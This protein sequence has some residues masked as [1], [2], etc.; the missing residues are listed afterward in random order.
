MATDL[1]F[2]DMFNIFSIFVLDK[3]KD[4][5]AHTYSKNL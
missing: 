3:D 5:D 1:Q 2:L 4:N